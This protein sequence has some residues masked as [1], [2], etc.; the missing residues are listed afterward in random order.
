MGAPKDVRR[1]GSR[2]AAS[3]LVLLAWGL[4]RPPAPPSGPACESPREA[5]CSEGWTVRV[6]CNPERPSLPLRGAAPLLFGGKLDLNRAPPAVLEVLP[7]IG[8]ARAAALAAERERRPFA[9]VDEVERV[10]GIGP[11]TAAGLRGWAEARP[12][13]PA[14]AAGKCDQA[15]RASATTPPGPAAPG[16]GSQKGLP[17]ASKSKRKQLQRAG[18]PGPARAHRRRRS[19]IDG[20]PEGGRA[21]G[22]ASP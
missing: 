10:R 16:T 20:S 5:R 9:S 1:A 4:A 17:I 8:P 3:A 21:C 6:S 18:Q 11:A 7:G 12:S 2:A 19:V 22:L 13:R 14:P 15:A